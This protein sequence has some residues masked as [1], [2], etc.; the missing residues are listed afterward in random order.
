VSEIR[1]GPL[2]IELSMVGINHPLLQ[3][4]LT[5]S[6]LKNQTVSVERRALPAT[7]LCFQRFGGHSPPLNQNVFIFEMASDYQ[8]QDN[9]CF[10]PGKTEAVTCIIKSRKLPI[11]T[12]GFFTFCLNAGDDEKFPFT[13]TDRIS[14][15]ID[16]VALAP[17]LMLGK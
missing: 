8:F 2:A 12:Y 11:K 6:H 15:I 7:V 1:F 14:R 5:T 16:A 13:Q 17:S 10:M 3:A 4:V 9:Y